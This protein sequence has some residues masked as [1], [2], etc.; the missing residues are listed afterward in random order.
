MDI[1][2]STV[3]QNACCKQLSFSATDPLR[4]YIGN[5]VRNKLDATTNDKVRCTRSSDGN[6]Y[7]IETVYQRY[8]HEF[9]TLYCSF[10]DV[11]DCG[12]R[13]DCWRIDITL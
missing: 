12:I 9:P 5:G 4:I 11:C 13:V 6:V 8:E 2:E 7:G 1:T 10:A 3:G